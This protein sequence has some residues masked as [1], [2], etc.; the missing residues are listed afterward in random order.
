[1]SPYRSILVGLGPAASWD[2][3][4]A[5][6]V[7]LARRDGARLTVLLAAGSLP[8]TVWLAPGLP[9]DLDRELTAACERRRRAVVSALP[10]DMS[11]TTIVRRGDLRRALLGEVRSG[12]H[13]LVIVGRRSATSRWPW[14]DRAGRALLRRSPVPLLVAA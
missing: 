12:A 5:H 7:W 10:Q 9:G 2:A 3:A 14:R 8:A 4:L 6:A 1:M 13:D 11:V